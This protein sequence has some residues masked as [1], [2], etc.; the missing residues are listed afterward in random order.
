MKVVYLIGPYSGTKEQIKR[1]IE[2][3]RLAASDLRR[4]GYAVIVPHLESLGCEDS[5][6]YE[7]WMKHGFALIEKADC[8][9]VFG[10]YVK[11]KGFMREISYSGLLGKELI[12][13][14]KRDGSTYSAYGD[15]T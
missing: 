2:S 3:A 11:S 13:I 7:G 5:L 12:A 1:N 10:E 9:A 6:D 8:V 15:P 4:K 14:Y